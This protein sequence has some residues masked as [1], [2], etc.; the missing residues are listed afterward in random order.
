MIKYGILCAVEKELKPY[1]QDINDIKT[2]T[3]AM[4]SFHQGTIDNVDVVAVYFGVGKVNAAIAAQ[5]LIDRFQVEYI[6]ISGTAGGLKPGINVFDTVVCTEYICHDT[7]N[8]IFTDYHPWMKEPKFYADKE[9]ISCAEKVSK[10]VSQEVHFGLSTTGE[11]FMN[12]EN[13]EAIC[14][15]MENIAVAHVCYVNKIP[16]IAIR[17]ISDNKEDGGQDAINRSF[18]KASYQSYNLV[19]EIISNFNKKIDENI[20]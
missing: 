11:I 9:L 5:I 12:L 4:L 14:V 16:F 6:I 2:T 7:N 18:D 1:L 17:S 10:N 3:V 13:T 15:E 19:K 20:L 8:E